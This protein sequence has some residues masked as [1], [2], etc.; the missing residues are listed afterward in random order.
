MIVFD[1]NLEIR[2]ALFA[3]ALLLGIAALYIAITSN[4]RG[5]R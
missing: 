5:P 2:L 4:E 3:I 1:T